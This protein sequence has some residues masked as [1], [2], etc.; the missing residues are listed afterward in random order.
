MNKQKYI[1]RTDRAGVFYGFIESREGSEAVLTDA[2]RVWRW[3]GAT[4]CIQLAM[5]GCKPSSKLTAPAESL[6]VLGVI[7]IIPVTDAARARMDAIPIWR[8]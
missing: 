4:D 7:E 6:T 3:E 8:A 5:E 1:I 2:R